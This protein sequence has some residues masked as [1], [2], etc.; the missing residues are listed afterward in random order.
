MDK[1]KDTQKILRYELGALLS[2]LNQRSFQN[3]GDPYEVQFGGEIISLFPNIEVFWRLFIIPQTNRIDPVL[4]LSKEESGRK[5]KLVDEDL[6]EVAI[7]HYSV[8]IKLVY[9]LNKIEEDS[10]SN[11]EEFYAHLASC[12]DVAEEFMLLTY[13][14]LN[15]CSGAESK[16]LKKTQEERCF[17]HC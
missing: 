5:R 13:K 2:N 7:Y 10:V 15:L 9:A 3:N 11:F 17:R 12:C 16:V 14:I 6:Y 4:H 1:P 8:F